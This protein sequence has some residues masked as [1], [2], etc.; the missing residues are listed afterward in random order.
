MRHAP[1]PSRTPHMCAFDHRL[2]LD[3]A[4]QARQLAA[5]GV[6]NHLAFSIP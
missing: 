3:T 2:V 1:H 6:V 4:Q 5:S